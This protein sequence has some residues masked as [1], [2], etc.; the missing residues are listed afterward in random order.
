[1]KFAVA[2]NRRIN[3]NNRFWLNIKAVIQIFC[4]IIKYNNI[5][6]NIKNNDDYFN[7]NQTLL[8]ILKFQVCYQDL[9]LYIEDVKNFILINGEYNYLDNKH[10]GFINKIIWDKI[11]NKDELL[12]LDYK[13]FKNS[14]SEEYNNNNKKNEES[15][16]NKLK[17]I[18][19]NNL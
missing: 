19:I 12:N 13:I 11:G 18:L 15:E 7:I 10:E 6:N 8:L 2:T 3:Y 14:K 4:M 16:E 1:M 17:Y 9:I 5:F